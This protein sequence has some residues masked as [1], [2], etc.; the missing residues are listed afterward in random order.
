VNLDVAVR[1]QREGLTL[2]VDL[3]IADETVAIVGPNGAGKTTLLHAIA[4]LVGPDRGLISLGGRV[5]VDTQA[6]V[7]VPPH[8]RDVGLAFQD[9]A[10]F[11]H[12]SALDN[13]AYGLRVRGIARAAARRTAGEWLEQFGVAARAQAKPATLSGGEAQRVAVARA[14]AFGP[15]AVL[16]DEPLAGLDVGARRDI[17]RLLRRH[18][19][20]FAGPAIVVTHDIVDAATLADRI[21]VLE[22]GQVTH[23]GTI[24][25]LTRHPTTPWAARLAG[26]N[27]YRGEA[28]GTDLKLDGG[29]SLRLAEPVDGQCYATIAPQAVGVFRSAPQGTPRNVWPARIDGFDA[30]GDRVRV[31]LRGAIE[32]TAEIT[33]GAAADLDLAGRD[34]V[35]VA[36]KATEISTYPV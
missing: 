25:V 4:G 3:H 22:A 29:A 34:T 12:R 21:V 6:Q 5:L 2:D 19:A 31:H 27:L 32:I 36:V 24:D 7:F 33:A 13:V 15:R 17:R 23:D 11:P 14:L 28:V 1:V 26:L 8:E 30:H 20:T 10:L 35:Y 18:L 16:L 9:Q